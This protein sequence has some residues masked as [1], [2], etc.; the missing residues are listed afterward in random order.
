MNLLVSQCSH[1]SRRQK[2]RVDTKF[3]TPL[4]RSVA[5]LSITLSL[6]LVASITVA[7]EKY[8]SPDELNDAS[9]EM[10]LQTSK[11]IKGTD[12]TIPESKFVELWAKDREPKIY[13]G[14]LSGLSDFDL[15]NAADI[16]KQNL[17]PQYSDDQ[18]EKAR[19]SYWE[20]LKG[21]R[22]KDKESD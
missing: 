21:Q 17:D 11:F 9:I 19:N 13:P 15:E 7:A 12:G 6:I 2:Q 8:A 14:K 5:S 20:F 4:R 3:G 10:A 22:S 18:K 16:Y 1:D